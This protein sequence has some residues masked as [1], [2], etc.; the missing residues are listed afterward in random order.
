MNIDHII[1]HNLDEVDFDGIY[2][3]SLDS[4]QKNWPADTSIQGE[5]IKT[6]VINMIQ[7]ALNNEWPG[8]NAHSPNDKHI[9][10][11]H[12]DLDTNIDMGLISAYIT[13]DGIL[14][15]RHSFSRVDS[16]G[17]R[18]YL[19]L[20]ETVEKRNQFYRDIGISKIKYNLPND[21]HMYKFLKYKAGA[22]NYIIVED[23]EHA[24]FPGFRTVITA[25]IL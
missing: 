20:P 23:T 25:P 1:I 17:S 2:A 18:N 16:S 6:H 21:S 15:G 10:F 4:I 3:G 11:K 13:P 9:L 5:E 19:Y 8:L 14:D 12:V 24:S 22:G 7:S